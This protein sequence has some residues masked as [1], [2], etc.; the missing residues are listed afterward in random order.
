MW[1]V[2]LIRI[3]FLFALLWVLD[4]YL[5]ENCDTNGASDGNDIFLSVKLTQHEISKKKNWN[6][7]IPKFLTFDF[8]QNVVNWFSA[9]V[10]CKKDLR[11]CNAGYG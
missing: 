4:E 5:L 10:E 3:N 9:E 11:H 2:F 1:F 6:E 8:S 7:T